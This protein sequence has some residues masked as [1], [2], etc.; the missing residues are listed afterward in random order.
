MEIVTVPAGPVSVDLVDGDRICHHHRNGG[1]E[2]QSLAAWATMFAAGDVV[3]DVGAYTGIYSL[4]AAKLGAYPEAFEPL[5]D[6]SDRLALN[7][8]INNVQIRIHR[9][10][11]GDES[12]E[13]EISFNPAVPLTSGASLA[14]GNIAQA[15]VRVVRLDDIANIKV[16]A[17]KIDVERAE[18]Q[19][20]RG[21]MQM[22]E[23]CKPQLLIEA[24]GNDERLNVKRLLPGYRELA[25]L[26]G[27]N[28]RM[29]PA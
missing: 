8:T 1:F 26:D 24:L 29:V 20:L 7:A 9:C 19:V 25:L 6:V 16:A 17:I 13:A 12:G 22:I 14:S 4:A 15:S 2:V 3:Y 28:M 27:R 5:T 10:A 23:A 18:D 21:A 11:V